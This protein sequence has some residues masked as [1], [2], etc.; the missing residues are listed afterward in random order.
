MFQEL[1]K[2][3]KQNVPEPPQPK[4]K[5][6]LP[7]VAETPGHPKKITIHVGGKNS[8]AG[9]PAPA[10]GQSGEVEAPRNETPVSRNPF[11]GASSAGTSVNLS[12]LEKARSMSTS[13]GPPSPS[14]TG[15]AK[16]EDTAQP[17]TIARPQPTPT[18]FQHFVPVPMNPSGLMPNGNT[19]QYQQ[20][21]PPLVQ[22]QVP[23]PPPPP[24]K[25][26][27][28]DILEAQ[29][30]RPHPISKLSHAALA[31]TLLTDLSGETEALMPRLVITTHPSLQIENK[32]FMTFP[33]S[34]TE[35]QQEIVVNAPSSHFRLQLKPQVASFLE[36]EQ[37]EWK[38]N[39]MHETTRLY[40]SSVSFDKRGEP[41]F[42]ATLRYGINR[43]EV[44]IV[45]ALPRGMKAPNGL[46]MEMERFVVHFN[47]LRH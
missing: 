22:V 34:A 47:L 19:P 2:E 13:A 38:L 41:V 30:Y 4:I 16:N 5:L 29:K 28:T 23:P 31:A 35:Y 44:N 36:A 8:V 45:A 10:T 39:V 1:L 9:S 20:P 15:V 25:R 33:A 37:R 18:T 21:P 40:P 3:A 6:K 42:D 11:G 12:Q 14:V 32:F 27:A 43:L 17:V 24:P 7:Q 46:N 26:S